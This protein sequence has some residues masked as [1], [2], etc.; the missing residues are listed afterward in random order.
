MAI[1]TITVNVTTKPRWWF[2]PALYVINCVNLG[3]IFKG[4][5]PWVPMWLVRLGIQIKISRLI[6]G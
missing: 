4:Y 1:S 5:R 2:M 3:A 6:H